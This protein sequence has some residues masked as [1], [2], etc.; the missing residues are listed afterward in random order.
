M[1]LI[2]ANQKLGNLAQYCHLEINYI[3]N[4]VHM[5]QTIFKTENFFLMFRNSKK[6]CPAL[7]IVS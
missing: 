3:Y 2:L 4:A 6:T 7:V 1:A 5:K